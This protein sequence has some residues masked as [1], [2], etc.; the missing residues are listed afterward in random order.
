MA[1]VVL[2]DAGP[3][4]ALMDHR[5]EHHAWAKET[6]TTLHLPLIT[7]QPVLT[8]AFFLPSAQPAAVARLLRHV[9]A[10]HF[11]DGLG[12]AIQATRITELMECYANVPMSFA[13][14]SLVAM[15]ER[16]REAEICTLNSDSLIYRQHGDKPL[17]LIA[18]FVP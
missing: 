2:L 17:K 10:G 3:L 14:A 1:A 4:V 13:D 7:C 18:P 6:F 12:F 8:E 15:A 16:R 11:V 5:E 9:A